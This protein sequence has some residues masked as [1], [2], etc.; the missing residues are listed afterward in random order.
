MRR[1]K[2]PPHIKNKRF[3][4]YKEKSLYSFQNYVA[5]SLAIISQ[6]TN[7]VL[8]DADARENGTSLNHKK[9]IQMG[10]HATTLLSHVK[11][12]MSQRRRN[13]IRNI[14][15]SQYVSLCGP[16]PGFK[17][18]MQK[19]KITDSEHLLGDGLK[20]A[21]KKAKTSNNIFKKSTNCHSSSN[22]H[23]K[24]KFPSNRS[25]NQD[26]LYHGHKASSSNQ[27]NRRFNN[28]NNRRFNNQ[29]SCPNYQTK[30]K[31]VPK[32]RKCELHR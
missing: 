26:F 13:N 32:T 10:I 27:K 5:K 18:A 2:L 14:V 12:D 31:Y 9:I 16:K 4:T 19:P 7:V 25:Q 21:A 22:N 11:A 24:F 23:S 8:N 29:N 20:K 17:A 15:E 3:I 1:L 28:Q 6:M 30:N